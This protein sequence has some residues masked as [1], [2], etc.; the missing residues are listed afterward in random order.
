MNPFNPDLLAA[1]LTRGRET[2]RR[3]GLD[4]LLVTSLPNIRYLTG[5]EGTAAR[6][7]LTADA[8]FLI[9]DGRYREAVAA[10]QASPEACPGLRLH[11]VEQGYDEAT[12]ELAGRRPG[13]IGIEADHLT[14][15]AWQLL[16]AALAPGGCRL[17]PTAGLIEG[18]R[19]L[20]DSEEIAVLRE[21]AARLSAV[22]VGVMAELRAGLQERQVA[23]QIEAG[24]WRMG[25]SK[26]AFDTIVASG[27]SSALPHARA[28]DRL[29]AAG[30]L[31]VLDFGGFYSGYAVDL[32]RTVCIGEP[33]SE[34]RRLF[35]A[36]RDA[37]A[38]AIAAVQPGRLLS[39]VDG[40]A[41]AVLADRG[42]AAAFVHGTGHGLG[43]EVHEAPRVGPERLTRPTGAD[44][45]QPAPP[46]IVAPGMVFTIEPGAYVPGLGGVRIEDDVLVTT[47]GCDVLTTVDR[48]LRVC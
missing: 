40:A 9:T 28:G 19:V 2:C 1:R 45:A 23:H 11:L 13:A 32:T 4:A 36:V 43:L 17:V 27:P 20:K 31:V 16:S 48:D 12:A 39:E 34:R 3:A 35:E 5:F 10:R 8:L 18:L 37:Q 44:L 41:R 7:L 24:L 33:S 22:A 38:A 47:D 29:L 21:A 42:L 26:P 25:F 30:D 14:V 15:T 6:L 46:R